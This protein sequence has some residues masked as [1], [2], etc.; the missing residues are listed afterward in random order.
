M[1]WHDISWL[2]LSIALVVA[3]SA[4]V[5][6]LTGLLRELVSVACLSLSIA[7]AAVYHDDAGLLLER[8]IGRADFAA[9]VAFSAILVV[10]W[11]VAGTFGLLVAGVLPRVGLGLHG[12]LGASLLGSL[13]G[14]ALAV[15]VLMVLTVYLPPDNA[16][17]RASRLYPLALSGARAFARVLPLE[18]RLILL[19]RLERRPEPALRVGSGF[20]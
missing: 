1:T 3:M 20:V 15:I 4:L 14:A 10:A 16:A 17:F 6:L 7:L 12:R 18:E 2:D 8:W 9:L 19:R 13:K 5:A 11:S